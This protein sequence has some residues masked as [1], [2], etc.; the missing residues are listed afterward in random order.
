MSARVKGSISKPEVSFT[1]RPLASLASVM[2]KVIDA[3]SA[4]VR[5][6]TP[7]VPSRVLVTVSVPCSRTLLIFSVSRWA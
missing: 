6:L 5:L 1:R 7:S 3:F 4:S 2:A